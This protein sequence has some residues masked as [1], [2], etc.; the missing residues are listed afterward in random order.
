M[1]APDGGPPLQFLYRH[2]FVKERGRLIGAR[3]VS[4]D[5]RLQHCWQ[6]GQLQSELQYRRGA[7]SSRAQCH[8]PLDMMHLVHARKAQALASDHDYRTRCH[9]FTALPEDLKMSWAKRAHALQSEVGGLWATQQP[10]T[11]LLAPR[12]GV[13]LCFFLSL[14]ESPCPTNTKTCWVSMLG[15]LGWNHSVI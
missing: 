5:P 12:L 3:S 4:D 9:E 7:A 2:D 13:N 10:L 15:H 1:P 6:V 14:S 8:L 11:F